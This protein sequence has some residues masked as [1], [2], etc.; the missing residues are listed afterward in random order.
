MKTY[1]KISL[2][3]YNFTLPLFLEYPRLKISTYKNV[4]ELFV[5][6]AEFFKIVN[7]F[8]LPIFNIGLKEH[9]LT[10]TLALHV[11]FSVYI[12]VTF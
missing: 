12:S 11:R 8:D 3:R 5:N 9:I 4:E 1:L 2:I 10:M 7:N 6:R